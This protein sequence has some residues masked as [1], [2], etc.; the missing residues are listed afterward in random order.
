MSQ[1]D[2]Q[3]PN[4]Y[5]ILYECI[6]HHSPFSRILFQLIAPFVPLRGKQQHDPVVCR[7][8]WGPTIISSSLAERRIIQRVRRGRGLYII[9]ILLLKIVEPSGKDNCRVCD[10]WT[11]GDGWMEMIHCISSYDTTTTCL[12]HHH[13]SLSL[14]LRLPLFSIY[15]SSRLPSSQPFA[16]FC[17]FFR[18]RQERREEVHLVEREQQ[19]RYREE[20]QIIDSVCASHRRRRRRSCSQRRD[21]PHA[22]TTRVLAAAAHLPPHTL[23]DTHTHGGSVLYGGGGGGGGHGAGDP[24]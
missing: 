16:Q 11:D 1:N 19:I 21:E 6:L 17:L 18:T 23:I 3:N 9:V 2:I 12:P 14:S 4:V 20:Q 10:G 13:L 22:A 7:S 5:N 8:L 15:Y 24:N